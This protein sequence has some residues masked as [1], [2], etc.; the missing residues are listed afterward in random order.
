MTQSY[1]RLWQ[2]V[3]VVVAGHYR[4]VLHQSPLYTAGNVDD[5]PINAKPIIGRSV[6]IELGEGIALTTV[7]DGL[8]VH[9][10]T[11]P[12]PTRAIRAV[13]W[14]DCPILC[15]VDR[16]AA[17]DLPQKSIQSG[18]Q[19]WVTDLQNFFFYY[20]IT[21]ERTGF[22]CRDDAG[23]NRQVKASAAFQ[24]IRARCCH[25][26][27]RHVKH[28]RSCRHGLTLLNQVLG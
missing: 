9:D 20:A 19:D 24:R 4:Y 7:Q 13:P 28:R 16:T 14:S 22:C 18:V 3:S 10:R 21:Q 23:S 1:I 8:L 2:C 15:S 6:E 26:R 17:L 5:S 25:H 27:R 11:E 12:I